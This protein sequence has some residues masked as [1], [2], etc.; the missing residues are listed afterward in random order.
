MKIIPKGQNG[1]VVK[2]DNTKVV[3]RPVI[4]PIKYKIK[5]GETFV[6]DRATGKK[7]LIR[8]KN[9]TVSANRKST[10]QEQQDQKKAQQVYKQYEENKNQEEGMKNIQG[11]LTFLS[12]ST[13]IGP[14]FNNNDKSYLDNVMSGEGTG[15]TAG[16][17]AIDMLT[18]FAVGGA[19]SIAL[20]VVKYPQNVGKRAVE[21]AM[22]TT[23]F[24]NPLPDISNNFHI[25]LQGNNGGKTRLFH[26]GNYILTGKK[27]GPKGYYNSF[28]PF[29]SI[30]DP[31]TVKVSLRDRIRSFTQPNGTSYAYSG[32]INHV[33][34]IPPHP[35]GND[36]IDAFLYNKTI[37]PKFG[38]QKVEPDYGIHT[39]Y[40]RKWYPNKQVQVYE[41][42]NNTSIPEQDVIPEAWE[43][44][45]TFSSNFG[46]SYDN[47]LNAAGHLKQNGIY[48]GQKVARHQDIWKFNPSEYKQKWFHNKT[49]YN[50]Q[51]LYKKKLLDIGLRYVDKIGSPVITRTKWVYE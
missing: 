29:V 44:S 17:L 7:V 22:R 50:R 34:Q 21:T 41:V 27:I 40:V 11:L 39:N 51:P 9:E 2:S 45:K 26:I 19:K 23:A 12:P 32:Y 31:I 14:I 6:T 48:N 33:G 18:P 4:F 42:Q 25:M 46:A 49:D 3:Q 24:A 36:M 13:Y 37:D 20:N 43:S 30:S 35:D 28:A 16:N 10:Y 1:L 8:Q 5:P 38:V 47:I 15:D